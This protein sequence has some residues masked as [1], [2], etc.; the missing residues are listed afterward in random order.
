MRGLIADSLQQVAF[1]DADW[2]NQRTT[3]RIW[4]EFLA[5]KS[6]HAQSVVDAVRYR[7]PLKVRVGQPSVC[8]RCWTGRNAKQHKY[9]T[10]GFGGVGARTWRFS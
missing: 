4:E 1:R 5:G 10:S 3:E 9:S 7:A 8:F 6:Q 2:L